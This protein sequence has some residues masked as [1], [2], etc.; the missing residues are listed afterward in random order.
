[1]MLAR[2]GWMMTQSFLLL[3]KAWL[4]QQT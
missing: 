3:L 4:K 1:M 2:I